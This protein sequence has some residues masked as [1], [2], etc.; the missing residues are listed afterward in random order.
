[1]V[2]KINQVR[3]RHGLRPLRGSA[4]LSGSSRRYA[5]HLIRADVLQHS[6]HGASGRSGEV[7]AVQFGSSPRVGSTVAR[8]M[9]SPGHRA[10]LLSRSMSSLGAG[11]AQGRFGRTRAVVWVARVA[12]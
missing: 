5:A 7:L 9:N 8:W 11:F 10:V 6:S 1:M 12:G 3:A 2:Q 4:S